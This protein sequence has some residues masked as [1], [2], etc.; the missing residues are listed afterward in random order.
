MNSNI[1]LDYTLRLAGG[2]SY[3]GQ[4]NLTYLGIEGRICNDGWNDKAARVVCHE[5]GYPDGMAYYHYKS[6][7]DAVGPYWTTNVTCHG[8]ESN[9]SECSH[10]GFGNVQE[11]KGKHY[12]GVL[13]FDEQGMFWGIR[14]LIVYC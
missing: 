4:V 14:Y 8:N 5:L 9:I 1:F 2:S 11:C 13:C 12:A 10:V 7:M 6:D 3:T